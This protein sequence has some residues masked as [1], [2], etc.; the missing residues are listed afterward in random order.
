[1]F[2]QPGLKSLNDG[3]RGQYLR[4]PSRATTGR[5]APTP[6]RSNFGTGNTHALHRAR[7]VLA[8]VLLQVFVDE[9]DR[10]AALADRGGNAF[11]R[12]QPHIPAGENTGDTRFEEVGIEAAW[13][14]PGLHHVVTGQDISA[15]IACDVRRQPTGLRVGSNEDEKAAAI[16]SL[17]LCACAIAYVD[18]YQVGVTVRA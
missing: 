5:P 12:A 2:A 17:R 6:D 8:R 16:V 10:H 18:R 14:A 7:R 13:P 4:G 3:W 9:S 1:M 15:C 11:D